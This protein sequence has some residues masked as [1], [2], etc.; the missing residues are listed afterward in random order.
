[1]RAVASFLGSWEVRPSRRTWGAEGLSVTSA[2][3]ERE[4]IEALGRG[5][6]LCREG[7]NYVEFN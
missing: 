4:G 5:E 2:F 1:M 3:A 7:E 6:G